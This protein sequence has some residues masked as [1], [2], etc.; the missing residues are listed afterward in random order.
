MCLAACIH[1]RIKKVYY[2][3][4]D[5]KAG[6]VSLNFKLESDKRLNHQLELIYEP[7]EKCSKILSH[8]FKQK[9]KENRER[10]L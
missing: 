7:I 8:F 10:K 3:A 5:K 4:Q 6:S 9:R 2:G 1:S